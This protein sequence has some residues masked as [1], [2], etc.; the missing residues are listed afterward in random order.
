[1]KYIL[2]FFIFFLFQCSK[3]KTVFICGD[4]VCVNK[5]EANQYFEENLSIEVKIIGNKKNRK[6][7]LVE[8]NLNNSPD[9]KKKIIIKQKENT[10]KKI[11][12]LNNN[13]IVKIKKEIKKKKKINV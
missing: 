6:L 2:I 11:K 9:K 1:M 13:E 10:S 7:D 4:H 8:L 12:T 3:P 5:L